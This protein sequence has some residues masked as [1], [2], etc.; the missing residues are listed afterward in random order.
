MQFHLIILR[1]SSYDTCLFMGYS[2][3]DTKTN[4][5]LTWIMQRPLPSTWFE[6]NEEIKVS[7]M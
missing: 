6:L 7:E 5:N 3:S 4:A 1:L 2:A